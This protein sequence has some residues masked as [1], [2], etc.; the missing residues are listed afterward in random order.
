MG[1]IAP[2]DRG[3]HILFGVAFNAKQSS[4][5]EADAMSRDKSHKNEIEPHPEDGKDGEWSR[6][7]LERM[8][9]KFVTAVTREKRQQSASHAET[10]QNHPSGGTSKPFR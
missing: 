7:R 8:D 10:K 1:V 4:Q 2:S 9:Y 6:A 3:C 5:R